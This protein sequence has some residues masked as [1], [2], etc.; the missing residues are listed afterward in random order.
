M[1]LNSNSK[2]ICPECGAALTQANS[3]APCPACLWQLGMEA[4]NQKNVPSEVSIDDAQPNIPHT[5]VAK[6]PQLEILHRV[7]S[8]GM[9]DVYCARQKSLNRLVALKVI[10]PESKQ[11]LEFAKR[12]TREAQAL[13]Q[14]SHPNIVTV[15]DFGETNDVYYFIMEYVDGIN[16]R[17]M[18]HGGKLGPR[19][20][21]EIVPAVCD[22]LQYAHDKGIVHRDIKP[23]N[24]LVDTDGQV[25]IADFGLAKLLDKNT[26]MPSLT[27]ANQVM[28]TLHYMAP[29]QFERPLDVDHRADIYSLGVVI[30]ELLTGELPLGR[31]APPS[32]KS[33]VGPRLDQ[34]VMQTLEKEPTLRYQQVSHLKSDMQSAQT[35]QV[36]GNV[37]RPRPNQTP[38]M[39]PTRAYMPVA[40]PPVKH[41]GPKESASPL[42]GTIPAGGILSAMFSP[43]SYRNVAYLL[44]AFPLGTLYFVYTVTGLSTGVS[45]LIVW[46]GILIL[47]GF[48]LGLRGIVWLERWLTT[49][50]LNT[51][52][53]AKQQLEP[54]TLTA[55]SNTKESWVEK[56]KALFFSSESWAAVGYCILKF[57]LSIISFV[58]TVALIPMSLAFCATP[59]LTLISPE[60]GISIEG[61]HIDHPGEAM[62]VFMVGFLLLMFSFSI[63]NRLAWL[64]AQL[65]KLCLKRVE[66]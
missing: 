47:L 20:A 49:A 36:D 1:N 34:I 46:I 7:G 66:K 50:L 28:G 2:Q 11:A 4:W 39:Q 41:S 40:S 23:E 3:D 59:I 13:A 38:T 44:L 16:L 24:I 61:W 27:Q 60:P 58:V 65:A 9:G 42:N 19:Q 33:Q 52:I 32:S 43:Q 18:L 17:Q 54:P 37:P 35:V 64:H 6:F 31:F 25:K 12:F 14:L 48:F 45:T 51:R 29:E 8:G 21:L 30:Y 5:L 62:P 22:A 63:I 56:A 26:K 53:P 55:T 15:H 57:P 10:R